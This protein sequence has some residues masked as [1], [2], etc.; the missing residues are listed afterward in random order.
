MRVAL[1]A[2]VS[3]KD[4]GQSTDDQLPALRRYAEAH[5]Y[6]VYKEFLL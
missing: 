1:Y 2:R 3:I 4:K 5:G 6:T